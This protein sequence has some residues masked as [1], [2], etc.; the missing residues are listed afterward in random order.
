MGQKCSKCVNNEKSKQRN[1]KTVATISDL[2]VVV[3]FHMG[4]AGRNSTGAPMKSLG[5]NYFLM[6]GF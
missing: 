2:R 1:Q 5:L 3:L 6:A 4:S